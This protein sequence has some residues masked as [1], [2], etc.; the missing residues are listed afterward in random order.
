M[1]YNLQ[2]TQDITQPAT[3]EATEEIPEDNLNRRN[4][5]GTVEGYLQAIAKEDYQ[6]AAEYLNLQNI[7]RD[8]FEHNKIIIAKSLKKLLDKGGTIDTA[9]LI[10]SDTAGKTEDKLEKNIDKVGTLQIND[11]TIDILLEK[12]TDESGYPIWLVAST[13]ID[14]IPLITTKVNKTDVDSFLPDFLNKNK[15]NGSSVGHWVAIIFIALLSIAFA[16]L[17]TIIISHILRY[18]LRDRLDNKQIKLLKAFFVPLRLWVAVT[19]FLFL[20]QHIGISILVRQYFSSVTL[21]LYWMAFL[22]LLWQMTNFVF[23]VVENK[24]SKKRNISALSALEFS[25]RSIKFF[26]IAAAVI[27]ILKLNDYDITSWLAAIGIGGIA[28]ALG[29]QKTIENIVGSISLLADQPIRVGDFCQVGETKGTIEQIGIRSTRI[30]TLSRTVVTIPNGEFSSQQIENYTRRDNFWYHTLLGLRYETSEDQIRY[31]LVEIRSV[32]YAH[33]K[34]N[35][36]PN[37]VRF[38]GFA[39]DS[40]TIEVYAYVIAADHEEFLEVQE[41]IHLRIMSIIEKSGSGFAF[42]SQ[43]VYLTRDKGLSDTRTKETENTVRIWKESNS[44]QNP[45]FSQSKIDEVINTIDYPPSYSSTG[46]KN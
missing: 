43:T 38:I 40:L 1:S 45:K 23:I 9:S 31:I 46:G 20:S 19:I 22:I 2:A 30:R 6:R 12:V 34:V 8:G 7:S 29:A 24:M 4:P 10:S 44:L 36:K 42:P 26:L 11:K 14:A 33:P 35:N 17:L 41:D 32:L 28:I 13:T 25:R 5:R 18:L 21:I 27:I 3:P 37:R 16:L 39:A 15:I